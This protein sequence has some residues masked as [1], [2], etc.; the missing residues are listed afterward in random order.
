MRAEKG[1]CYIIHG[2]ENN[3]ECAQLMIYN[4]VG[5][6]WYCVEEYYIMPD[7]IAYEDACWDGFSTEVCDGY[8]KVERHF[9]TNWI[10]RMADARQRLIQCGKQACLGKVGE[11]KAGDCVFC[12]YSSIN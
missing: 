5:E 6:D 11:L 9:A 8:K 10:K 4:D 1:S 7:N 3:K 2:I 12:N